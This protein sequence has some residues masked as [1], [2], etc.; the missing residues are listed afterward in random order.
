M[1]VLILA[2]VAAAAG[3][4]AAEAFSLDHI[5]ARTAA[6]RTLTVPFTWVRHLAMLE[7]PITGAGDIQVDRGLRAVRWAYAEGAVQI[8]ADDR[9]RKWGADGREESIA[10]GEAGRS[11]AIGQM[12]GLLD[13]DWSGLAEL[14]TI[15]TDPVRP[16]LTCTARTP[17]IRQY[18]ASIVFTWRA[19]LTS[20][21]SIAFTTGD[22]DT[23]TWT[24]GDPVVDAPIPA[25]R[26][27]GP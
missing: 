12:R 8:F 10:G 19:D 23:T 26:F 15:T 14:F 18:V 24:F 5:R 4:S 11:A 13:G 27:R 17:D 25:E 6:V 21:E 22:G 20:P 2:F 16:V 9:I 7:D 3:L 1:R